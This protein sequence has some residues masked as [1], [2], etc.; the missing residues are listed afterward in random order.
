MGSTPIALLIVAIVLIT[1]GVALLMLRS[2]LAISLDKERTVVRMSGVF[3]RDFVVGLAVTGCIG[4]LRRA[5]V[6]AAITRRPDA[7]ASLREASRS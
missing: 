5:E 1:T 2:R 6:A 4:A 7:S 3:L